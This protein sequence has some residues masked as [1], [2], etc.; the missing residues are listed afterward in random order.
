MGQKLECIGEYE[1]SNDFGYVSKIKKYQAQNCRSCS[2]RGRCFKG[3]GDRIIEINHNLRRH[4][5]QA[6]KNL[7]S[8]EGLIHRS[9]RPIEPEA[10]FGQIKYNKGFNRFKLRGIEGVN[11]EFGLIAIAMNIAKLAKKKASKAKSGILLH[12]KHSVHLFL[13]N[14]DAKISFLIFT[15]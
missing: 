13:R 6:R 10:V 9:N 5:N 1:K 12:F 8:P 2:I 7:N 11:L 3:K 14:V 4:K 15:G